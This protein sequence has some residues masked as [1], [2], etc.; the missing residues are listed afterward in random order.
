MHAAAGDQLTEFIVKVNNGFCLRPAKITGHA[1]RKH[2]LCLEPK[3]LGI[4][5]SEKYPKQKLREHGE[6]QIECYGQFVP[7]H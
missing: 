2:V 1:I 4:S 3:S 7:L 5:G 6:K